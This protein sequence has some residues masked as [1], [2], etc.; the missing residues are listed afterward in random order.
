MVILIWYCG[1]GVSGYF[2][3][4]LVCVQLE[5]KA[6]FSYVEYLYSSSRM[7]SVIFTKA[8]PFSMFRWLMVP[9]PYG[10]IEVFFKKKTTTTTKTLLLHMIHLYQHHT[11][12][13]SC[14]CTCCD[15]KKPPLTL[16]HTTLHSILPA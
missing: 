5:P 11:L 3:R 7:S 6:N 9:Q 13:S 16:S 2:I 12:T 4:H 14:Q 8:P 10:D 15:V 1:M